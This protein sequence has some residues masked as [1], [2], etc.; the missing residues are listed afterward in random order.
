MSQTLR[1]CVVGLLTAAAFAIVTWVVGAFVLPLVTKSGPDRWA[2]AVGMGAAVAAVAGLWGQ[3]WAMH[4]GTAVAA[5]DRSITANGD[6]SGIASTGDG[7][8]NTQHR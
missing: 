2:I 1:W 5:V 8:T 3:S 7:T 6:I 4:E